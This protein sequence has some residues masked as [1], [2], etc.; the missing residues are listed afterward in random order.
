MQE[1]FMG[2]LDPEGLLYWIIEKNDD[3]YMNESDIKILMNLIFEEENSL[4]RE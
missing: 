2:V 4:I 3:F 1:N